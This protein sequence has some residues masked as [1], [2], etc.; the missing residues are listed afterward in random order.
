MKQSESNSIS[1]TIRPV[2]GPNFVIYV[3]ENNIIND[4]IQI[5]QKKLTGIGLRDPA[6]HLFYGG[7]NLYNAEAHLGEYNIKEG[8]LIDILRGHRTRDLVTKYRPNQLLLQEIADMRRA[9][10]LSIITERA[11]MARE[12]RQFNLILRKVCDIPSEP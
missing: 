10:R 9:K 6:W 4:L 1:L 2:T 5:I 3:K 12:L 11:R 8:S 7:K